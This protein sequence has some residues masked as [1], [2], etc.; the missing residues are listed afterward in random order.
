[1]CLRPVSASAS[2]SRILS[3]VPIGPGSIWKPSRGPSSWMSTWL[4][5]S[6]IC[7]P[8]QRCGDGNAS[9][10]DCDRSPQALQKEEAVGN[11]QAVRCTLDE[12]RRSHKPRRV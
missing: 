3:A 4:G 5:R 8:W 9:R 7:A 1:M 6:V 10:G 11:V 2:I 12:T